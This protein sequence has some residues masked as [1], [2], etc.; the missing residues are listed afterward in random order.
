MELPLV[1]INFSTGLITLTHDDG[2]P[3]NV[4]SIF[5]HISAQSSAPADRP[6]YLG[7]ALLHGLP[8]SVSASRGYQV[9]RVSLSP[10]QELEFWQKDKRAGEIAGVIVNAAKS[11]LSSSGE[12][13]WGRLALLSEWR[14]GGWGAN[15]TIYQ[16]T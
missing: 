2:D 12:Y 8:V 9:F 10:P 3:I 4:L 5:E 11:A 15:F 1:G 16:R 7:D 14:D 6:I 13:K